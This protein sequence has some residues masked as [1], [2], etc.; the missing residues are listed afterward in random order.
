MT[1]AVYVPF[2]AALLV[3]ALSRSASARMQPCHAVWAMTSASVAL[4]VTSAGALVVLA[5]PLP[6][7]VPLV[8]TL[9]RWQP[10]VIASRSPVP[11]AISI[12]SL[13]AIVVV[14]WRVVRELHSMLVEARE[15]RRLAATLHRF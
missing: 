13:L 6:A 9:G 2:A 7:R 4:A 1:V 3:A 5:C 12:A 15:A 10:R 11:L 14:G 8:A